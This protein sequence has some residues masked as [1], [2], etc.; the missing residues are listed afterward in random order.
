MNR[1]RRRIALWGGLGL[2]LVTGILYAF[3]PQA[4]PVD[5]ADV[6]RGEIVVTVDEE[7]ETRVRDVF[8]VSSPVPGRARRIEA[9]VGDEVVAG[10]TIVA[11][12]E[13]VDPSPLDL[14]SESEARA[15]VRAAE[16]SLDLARSE[17]DRAQAELDFARSELERQRGLRERGAAS[18]RDL[19]AAERAYK[20]ARA[21]VETARAA[22]Q[23][24]S[25]ELDQVR[26]RL[27]SPM[28]GPGDTHEHGDCDCVPLRA[29][30][31]GV[32]LRVE[33]ESEGVV[34]AGQ[35]LVEIGDPAD[36]EIIVDLLSADAVRVDPGQRVVID[37]WGGA[38]LLSGR[39]RRVEPFGF[40]KISALG[41]EEQRVNVVIDFTDAHERWARLG[42]GY[43]VETRIVLQE[44][45]DVLRVPLSALFR[46][47]EDWAVFVLEDGRARI[48]HVE[49][50]ISDGLMVEVLAGL[51][52]GER[53][54]RY[55]S[56]RVADG[57]R[58]EARRTG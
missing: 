48:R 43:R 16:A 49:R 50:G 15:A 52:A 21:V 8:V 39:V 10:E 6:S 25:F 40:T 36:L 56:A 47:G 31:S 26:A 53:V 4:V 18:E 35:P 34:G 57:V 44:A 37:E 14:R 13:P 51:E 28:R 1:R 30:V 32:V 7:G 38:G 23:A 22:I 5:F 55:P 54:V 45:H 41:I 17:L 33:H 24:R 46:N 9:E 12:I 27:M 20:T 2:L 3:R 19:S 42:H 29:P 58:I 11:E